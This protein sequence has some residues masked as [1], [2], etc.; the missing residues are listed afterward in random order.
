MFV[1]S[2][3]APPNY[4]LRYPIY[5]LTNRDHKALNR[6]TLRGSR[7]TASLGADA[8]KQR[9]ETRAQEPVSVNSFFNGDG[10]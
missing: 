2:V 9:P 8:M 10:S 1:P 6:G 4:P 7:Y 3:P 5:Q